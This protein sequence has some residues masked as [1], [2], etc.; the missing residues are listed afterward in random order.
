MLQRIEEVPISLTGVGFDLSDDEYADIVRR[1]IADE[2]G[3]GKGAN[4]VVKRSFVAD[5]TGY[6]P[7]VAL[8]LFPSHAGG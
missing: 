8:T 2:I 3:Q 5:I 6:T 4:F 7:A 1:V